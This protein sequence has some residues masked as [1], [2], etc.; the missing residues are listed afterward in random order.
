MTA[1]IDGKAGDFAET[2]IM[3][4]D[5][6]RAKYIAENFLDDAVE[7]TNI[8]NMFG[9]TGFYKG[10]RI[11]V[12]GH[13]MGIPSMVLY[14][15]ELVTDFNVKRIIRVGS[16]GATQQDVKI[17]DVILAQAAG[18]DS[19]TNAK[20]SSGYQ[21][22]TSATFDLLHKAYAISQQKQINVKVGNVFSGDMYYDPDEDMIPALE[23]FG[24]LGVDME[25][26]GLYGLAHHLGFESLAILTVSDHCLTG[27]ETSAEARQL[28]FNHMIELALETACQ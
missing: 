12:M 28:T 4:G 13:G 3:P 16:L 20:R 18:T 10:Q 27:E 2:M 8:R 23:R 11:S 5:P 22:A 21:M 7:V 17:N 14:A 6:L 24:V 15:H 25:V 19:P 1:H 26:A 9:Y